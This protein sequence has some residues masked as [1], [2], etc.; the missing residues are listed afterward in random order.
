MATFVFTGD[1][2][3]DDHRIHNAARKFADQ[4]AVTFEDITFSIGQRTEVP[5]DMDR[6][7]SK[8][9]GNHHF[10]EITDKATPVT[11][12]ENPRSGIKESDE[13][14]VLISEGAE[15]GLK[16]DRRMSVETMRER[17]DE[18]RAAEGAMRQ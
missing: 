2:R 11:R 17:I 8:L 7:I 12:A 5:D 13:K 18:A 4:T 14:D 9:R 1:P 6:L 15:L 10:H 3:K 16:L